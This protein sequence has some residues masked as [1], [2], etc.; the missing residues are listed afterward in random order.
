M[1][2]NPIN[3]IIFFYSE[4]VLLPKTTP[5]NNRILTFRLIDFNAEDFVFDNALS[6][7][8]LV[9]DTT[10]ITPEKN[11]LADGEVVIFD[12]NGLTSSHLTRVGLSSLRCFIKY[13]TEAHPVRIKQV[14]V[15]NSHSLLDVL[16]MLFKPFVGSKAMKVVHFH[17]PNSSTLFDY[18]PKNVLPT[19]F[20]GTCG[21]IEEH[22]YYWIHR[23]EDFR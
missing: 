6:V 7:F 22:K 16:V 17:K 23:T 1:D 13:M 15:V 9:N 10:I 18:V 21:P 19:E 8:S 11:G 2:E 12:L 4:M 3:L 5:E 20:L 14:H